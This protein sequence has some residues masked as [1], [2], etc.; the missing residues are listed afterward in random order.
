MPSQIGCLIS[1]VSATSDSAPYRSYRLST[2]F[3]VLRHWQLFLTLQSRFYFSEG[4]NDDLLTQD[5]LDTQRNSY[6]HSGLQSLLLIIPPVTELLSVLGMVFSPLART[7]FQTGGCS[8]CGHL[9]PDIVIQ[10]QL[11]HSNYI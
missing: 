7:S 9:Q 2:F 11:S 10:M 6:T 4:R 1:S 5:I 3:C 8:A